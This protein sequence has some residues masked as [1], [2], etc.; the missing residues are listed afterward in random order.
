MD[1]Y[2]AETQKWL[3]ERY[4]ITTDDGIYLAH[5]NIYG[6]RARFPATSRNGKL[7]AYSEEGSVLRYII[8]WNIIKALKTIQF[9]SLLD[10]GGSEGYMCGA[11]RHFFGVRVRS[12]DLSEEACK[13]AKEIFNVEADTVDGV[14][15]PYPDNS[16]DVVLSSE[17]LEHIP[18][19]DRVLH[20]LLR[21]A[22]KAVII[23]VPH[24]GPERIAKNIRDK[25]PHGHLHDFTLESFRDLV[26]SS[27]GVKA[28]GHNST[29]L[30]LPFRLVE[31]KAL[32]LES[33]NGIK[34][35]LVKLLNMFIPLCRH[36][37]NETMFKIL[38]N[39]DPFLATKLNT[40]RG[41]LYLITKDSGS[42]SAGSHPNLDIDAVLNF[43]VPLYAI[44][45]GVRE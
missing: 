4:R 33:R 45:E 38:L 35:P 18:E 42:F 36:F 37:M 40:Y 24:D 27:Y 39:I 23:T 25:V 16:F 26:P 32:D 43:R 9:D 1:S 14:S 28:A 22:R 5:Q 3:D 11:I 8:F 41:V 34:S 17:S 31:G 21:V 10:V 19:Y 2:T 7:S 13:R 30:K 44:P 15:L 6:F 12:C 29:L 20:E